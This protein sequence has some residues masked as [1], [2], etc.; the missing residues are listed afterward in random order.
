[1]PLHA[2]QVKIEK[3]IR[4]FEAKKGIRLDDEMRFIRSWIEKPLAIGAVTPSS[5]KRLVTDVGSLTDLTT[6]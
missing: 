6:G 2:L 5:K 3:S 1:M 4:L